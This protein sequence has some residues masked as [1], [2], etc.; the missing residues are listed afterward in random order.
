M[1]RWFQN[2]ND[3]TKSGSPCENRYTV[4]AIHINDPFA[5]TGK[6]IRSVIK[7]IK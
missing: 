4:Q 5:C 6:A 7:G 2:E 3:R 1:F